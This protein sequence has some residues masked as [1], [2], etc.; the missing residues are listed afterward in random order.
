MSAKENLEKLQK[1]SLRFLENKDEVK[2][3]LK[4]AHEANITN[5]LVS[6]VLL[7][8]KYQLVTTAKEERAK[9]LTSSVSQDMDYAEIIVSPEL[10]NQAIAGLRY[11]INNLLFFC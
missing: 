3:A 2:L 6:L 10:N 5:C 4:L 7:T 9:D 11:D 8:D 1:H